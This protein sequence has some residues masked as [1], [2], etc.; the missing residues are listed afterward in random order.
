[1]PA[2]KE[3]AI[4]EIGYA[5]YRGVL[6]SRRKNHGGL[7]EAL[8]FLEHLFQQLDRLPHPGFDV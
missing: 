7:L 8:T 1:M 3:S 5:F 2:G 6:K 4:W